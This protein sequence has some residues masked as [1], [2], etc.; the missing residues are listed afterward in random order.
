MVA[1]ESNNLIQI[2]QAQQARPKPSFSRL[3]ENLSQRKNN[4]STDYPTDAAQQA[5]QGPFIK[6]QNLS[7]LDS[8]QKPTNFLEQLTPRKQK[9]INGSISIVVNQ[10]Q[11]AP[12]QL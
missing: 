11:P 2:V 5:H 10:Q 8:I 4:A 1:L 7:A 9:I 3:L 12:Q 6:L